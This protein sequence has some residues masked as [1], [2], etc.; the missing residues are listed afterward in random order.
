MCLFWTIVHFLY[1]A[2]TIEFAVLAVIV[3]DVVW[4]RYRTINDA[5]RD[6]EAEARTIQR[7]EAAE[8]RQIRRERHEILRKHWQ[9]LQADLILLHRTTSHLSNHKRFVLTKSKTENF[10]EQVLLD[11]IIRG[12]PAELAEFQD[13]WGR[14]VASLNVFPEPRDV[15]VLELLKSIETLGEF[16]KNSEADVSDETQESLAKLV[17]RVADAAQL[18]N[19]DV[20]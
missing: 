19:V 7:E 9:E 14:V 2:N 1:N 18:Q 17:N 16:G 10:N 6:E 4:H 5:K 15:R 8:Q 3:Y 12:L 13:R 11:F 20:V